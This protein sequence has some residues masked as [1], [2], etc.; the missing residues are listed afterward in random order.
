[1]G[2]EA[3]CQI[4]GSPDFSISKCQS[5]RDSADPIYKECLTTR[6]I[7]MSL[8]IDQSYTI[9]SEARNIAA[10]IDTRAG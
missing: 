2:K 4:I 1:M 8:K 9:Y 7:E 3:A 10:S 5:C 6:L